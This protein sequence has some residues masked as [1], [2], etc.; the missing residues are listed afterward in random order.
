MKAFL[1][2]LL[3]ASR[4][5]ASFALSY[6]FLIPALI[7]LFPML[8]PAAEQV[9]WQ[10]V[11]ELSGSR[12]GIC[13]VA[14]DSKGNLALELARNTDM[15]VLLQLNTPP[16]ALTALRERIYQA[17]F[18]GTRI[19]IHSG[20][21]NRVPLAD[22][23]PDV[24]IAV[25][26]TD[27]LP[28][29]EA[30]RVVHPGGKALIDS[31]IHTKPSPEGTDV[32]S[33][34]YHG[35]DNNPVSKDQI[36]RAPYLTRFLADPRYAP[37]PQVAVAAGGRVFK[38]FGHIAFKEREEP[39]L[40]TLAAFNGYNGTLLWRQPISPAL[41]VHRNTIIATPDRLYFGDDKS[42]KVYDAATGQLLDEIIP[43]LDVAGGTFWKWMAL[44]NGILY[45]LI[46][47]QEK[48][49][50]NTITPRFT[51]HGWP[52][53]PLSP[54]FNAPEHQWGFGKMLLA[55]DPATKKVLWSW[56]EDEPIDS[57]A[58]CMSHGRLYAL[59]FGKF[60]LCLDARNGSLF[61]RKT[62]ESAPEL[63]AAIGP[64]SKRQD[65]RTNWRTTAYL[66]CTDKALYFSGPQVE[67][68]LA[69]SASD[70]S[71]LWQ[72]PYNNYQ[73]LIYDDAL[74]GISGQID[75]DPC[76][77]FDLLTGRVLDE[78]VV[79]RRA[80]TRPTA[81]LDGI[82]FR[83]GEGSTRI[84]VS[85]DSLE[86]VSPMRPNCHDGVTIAHG[87]LYWW[88]SVCDCNLSLYGITA[89]GP[90]GDF[91]FN[92]T[93]TEL[94]R[95][96]TGISPATEK[97]LR[98][99]Q[100][101]PEDWPMFRANPQGTCLSH[102]PSLPAIKTWIKAWEFSPPATI[103][104]TA[105]IAA[106]D[107]VYVGGA[108]GV[109]QCF[110][111]ATGRPVWRSFTS[112]GMRFPPAIAAGRLV[113]GAGDG[114]V[115]CFDSLT[116]ELHWRF[117]AA[118][119]ERLILVYGQL[120]SRWPVGS[121]IMADSSGT[122]YA[123]AGLANY[124]GT[125]VYALDA[126]TGRIKWQNNNSGFLDTAAR[127]GAAVQGHFLIHQNKLW[128]AGGNAV[129][130]VVYNLE[131]GRCESRLRVAENRQNNNLIGA[132]APRGCELYAVGERVLVGGKPLYAHPQ[133]PVYD[134]SVFNKAL[135]VQIQGGELAWINNQRVAF[136][137]NLTDAIRTAI[138]NGRPAASN[139]KP[140]W[141]VSCNDSRAI[142][143]WGRR[144]L[145]SAGNEIL[146]IEDGRIVHRITLPSP[147]VPWGLALT[148][149]GRL[150]ASLE[151]GNLIGYE[152]H[153]D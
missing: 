131:N 117:R 21:F 139:I 9:S 46:G 86:L 57:R 98:T 144:V 22:D 90:A 118:P 28:L 66:K 100:V 23:I 12:R 108:D 106:G 99:L 137:T 27:G 103:T 37:L 60:L 96:E 121:G 5:L 94:E 6:R 115:Y 13:V 116:G 151:G 148:S 107:Y 88:P 50:P 134:A 32:W 19:Y 67:K 132:T 24:F 48:R 18:Y 15:T 3:H 36:A 78:I 20:K 126:A 43:P 149:A 64:Y 105:P 127:A 138:F 92:Q 70:G 58:V 52:W 135:F 29:A 33:H 128:M 93:A 47:E 123:A 45:A 147:T 17:G 38:A 152:P 35:P 85:N 65:W 26:K 80:C 54:G 124:D 153:S 125:H 14:G 95:L 146:A 120:V 44:D 91:Q 8:E 87:L 102:A 72:H 56:K 2:C 82:F 112:G 150:V 136:Y 122:I 109:V 53:A 41:M 69:V 143:I 7:L 1:S 11:V 89:L 39:W 110:E 104:P 75:R 51:G 145:V 49:D 133:Y 16:A 68:L 141:E 101:K 63:F 114:W 97:P 130:P 25:D 4:R 81:T 71:V 84:N 77:K 31:Q 59:S 73:L 129:S 111:S 74:Y 62:P 10:K 55:I 30:L 83:A 140:V 119:E 76:R 42:C 79:G 40:N 113:T 61:W 34:P 142:V